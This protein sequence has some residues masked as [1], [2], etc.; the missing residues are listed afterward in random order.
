[1]SAIACP[2]CGAGVNARAAG[3]PRCGADPSLPSEQARAELQ[4]RG[5][6]L[7]TDSPAGPVSRRRRLVVTGVALA[8]VLV[9]LTPLWLGYLGP[10]AAARAQSW[11][12]WRTHITVHRITAPDFNTPGHVEL[13]VTY[14]DPWPGPAATP[15]QQVRFLMVARYSPL[16]PW[17]VTG[18]G[19]GP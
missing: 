17:V 5:M 7:P 18:S 8:V 10:E 9:L 6:S 16:L 14:S 19:T 13:A 1:M 11:L 3:C 15:G 2:V 4:R 12:P